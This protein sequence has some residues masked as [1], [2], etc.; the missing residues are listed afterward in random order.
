VSRRKILALCLAACLAGCTAS[1]NG[2]ILS[3]KSDDLQALVQ[4]GVSTKAD[5][6]TALGAA[7]VLSFDDG[8]EIWI[9]EKKALDKA[10]YLRYLPYVGLAMTAKDLL[11]SHSDDTMTLY[12]SD[13][14]ELAILFDKDGIARQVSL[15]QATV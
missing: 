7:A 1:G 8:H 2:T 14:G 9:Y 6:K 4:V 15:R 10:K 5:V 12:P 3:K 11:A 13:S